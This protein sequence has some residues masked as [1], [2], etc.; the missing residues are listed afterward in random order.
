MSFCS[1]AP[2]HGVV[3]AKLHDGVKPE[4]ERTYG[5]PAPT[6]KLVERF[7][8]GNQTGDDQTVLVSLAPDGQVLG[9]AWPVFRGEVSLDAG[10]PDMKEEEAA[11]LLLSPNCKDQLVALRERGVHPAAATPTSTSATGGCAHC[12]STSATPAPD[13]GLLVAVVAVVILR[14]RSSPSASRGRA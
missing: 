3:R 4:I 1:S 5:N 8:K 11:S 12:S 2:A 10:F 9:T 6:T 7:A 14:L 13:V